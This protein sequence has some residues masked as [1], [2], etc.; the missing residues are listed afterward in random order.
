MTGLIDGE[1]ALAA[2]PGDA[3]ELGLV[4]CDGDLCARAQVHILPDGDAYRFRFVEA[5]ELAIPPLLDPPAGVRRQWLDEQLDKFD[6]ILLL[7]Y[8][9]RW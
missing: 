2:A 6:F 3:Y 5:Q 7:F 1:S 4:L 8:R 9:G